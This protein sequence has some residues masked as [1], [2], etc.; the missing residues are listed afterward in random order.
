VEARRVAI[1][2]VGAL[3][4]RASSSD[5]SYKEMMFEAAQRAYADASIR[6]DEID[7]FVTC[8]EDFHEGTSIFDEYTPDQL[9]AVLKPMHTVGGDGIHGLADAAMQILTGSFEV[10][11]VEAHSKAS[12][13]LTPDH[14]VEYAADPVLVRPLGFHPAAIAGLEMN[15]FL[16]ATGVTA[17]QC[18]EVAARNAT[19]ALAN[20]LA[21][22]PARRTAEDV[23]RSP[24]A[25]EPLHE[26]EIA[27]PADGAVV[28]VLV[29]EERA[30]GRRPVW[31]RGV[32]WEND[33][34]SLESRDWAEAAYAR[35]AGERAYRMAGTRAIDLFE[36]DDTF[37]YK[38]LQHRRA[39]GVPG[40]AT[41]NASGGSIGVGN[42]L[43]ASGLYR[44]A[45]LVVQLRGEAGARQVKGARTGMAFSWRGLPTT[46]GA[47]VILGAD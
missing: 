13:I 24:A 1:I 10:V 40:G 22:H 23:L 28:V 12:N 17:Q 2:G 6:F 45:E 35:G 43:E 31:I 5:Q 39:L 47:A 25:F 27:P 7:S 26:L 16:H 41:V 21:A 42:L 36:I 33:A 11:A 4:A 37:A 29:S 30:R 34:W 3:P 9:G 18:A 46:S 20:P 15:R 8:A 14:L 32:G 38:E 19:R 44:V